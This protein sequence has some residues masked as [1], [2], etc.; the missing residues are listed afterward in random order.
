MELKRWN[1]F[2]SFFKAVC[3]LVTAGFIVQWIVKYH[4]DEDSTVLE[5]KPLA[6]VGDPEVS[7]CIKNPYLVEKLQATMAND[8]GIENVM[9]YD[10]YLRGLQNYSGIYQ[11][12]KFENVTLNLVEYLEAYWVIT[13]DGN[14][15]NYEVKKDCPGMKKC[16]YIKFKNNFNGYMYSGFYRCFGVE[17][18]KTICR[19]YTFCNSCFQTKLGRPYSQVH[20]AVTGR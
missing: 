17:I 5:Y 2:D 8:R 15:T 6:E 16:P 3:L 12:V 18:K 11:H 14:V 9:G 4:N 13:R 1:T 7:F 10:Q 20:G 19:K